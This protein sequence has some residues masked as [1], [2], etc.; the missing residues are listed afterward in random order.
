MG[1]VILVWSLA[2]AQEPGVAPEELGLLKQSVFDEPTPEPF[3]YDQDFP[4]KNPPIA[5]AFPGASPQIPRHRPSSRS[6]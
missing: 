3:T 1:I 4:G 6:R 2:F 5:P